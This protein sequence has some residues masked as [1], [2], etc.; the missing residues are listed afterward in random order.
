MLLVGVGFC[1]CPKRHSWI[2]KWKLMNT[3]WR[4]KG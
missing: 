3:V 4:R 1:V 2:Q